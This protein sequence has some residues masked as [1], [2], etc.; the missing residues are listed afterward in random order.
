M[1]KQLLW[2]ACMVAVTLSSG[3]L[4]ASTLQGKPTNSVKF[5]KF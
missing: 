1:K 5:T 2:L 3:Q 4:Y